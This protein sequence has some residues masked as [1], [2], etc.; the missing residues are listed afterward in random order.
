MALFYRRKNQILIYK[1]PIKAVKI[2][3]LSAPFVAIGIWMLRTNVSFYDNVMA[4]ASIVF[5]GFGILVGLFHMLDRRPQIIIDKT[6][7]WDRTTNQQTIPWNQILTANS[8]KIYNEKFVALKLKTEFESTLKHYKFA[9]A[10]NQQIGME[11]VNLQVT[12]TSIDPVKLAK[13]IRIMCQL[14]EEQRQLKLKQTQ[15]LLL[16]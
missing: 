3:L 16:R 1:K 7:I 12:Q 11:K 14:P 5:F 2:I 4:Y 13:F 10:I 9:H 6:G 8:L 15:K